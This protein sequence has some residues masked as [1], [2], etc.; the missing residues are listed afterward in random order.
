MN[1]ILPSWL[2]HTYSTYRLPVWVE[3]L[4]ASPAV[5]LVV[6]VVVMEGHTLKILDT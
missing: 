3:W 6:D 1:W 2:L 5:W 4:L